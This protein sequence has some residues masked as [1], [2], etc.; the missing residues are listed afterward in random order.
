MVAAMDELEQKYRALVERIRSYQMTEA[1]RTRILVEVEAILGPG[2][3][4]RFAAGCWRDQS[5]NP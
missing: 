2:V 5:C 4:V 3:Q 1:A